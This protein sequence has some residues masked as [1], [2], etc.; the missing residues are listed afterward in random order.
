MIIA[1][2]TIVVC[3]FILLC[4]KKPFYFCSKDTLHLN[5]RQVNMNRTFQIIGLLLSCADS[6]NLN[7]CTHDAICSDN[8]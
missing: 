2:T 1:K 4:H 6:V 3:N 7:A 8:L 5:N